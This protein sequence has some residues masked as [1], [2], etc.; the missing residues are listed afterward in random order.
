MNRWTLRLSWANSDAA[1]DPLLMSRALGLAFICG[2]S[3]ALAW[4]WFPHAHG[5]V[6]RPGILVT[7]LLGYVVAGILLSPLGARLPGWSFHAVV[8]SATVLITATVIMAGAGGLEL[9]LFYLWAMPPAFVFFPVRHAIAQ[10]LFVGAC[11]ALA[12]SS[13]PDTSTE[14]LIE[15]WIVLAGTVL[16]LGIVVRTLAQSIRHRDGELQRAFDSVSI[17][18]ALVS[19][20]GRWLEVNETLCSMLGRERRELVGAPLQA[21][22]HPDD[23][24]RLRERI[25]SRARMEGSSRPSEYTFVRA[26]GR[27]IPVE[28]RSATVTDDAGKPRYVF[29]QLRDITAERETRRLLRIS[30]QRRLSVLGEMMRAEEELRGRLATELHDDT[31]Q[32]MTSVLMTMDR[33]VRAAR[34][35]GADLTAAR[36]GEARAVLAEATERTRRLMFELRPQLLESGGLRPAVTALVE[37]A[38]R[39]AG[40]SADVAVDVGRYDDAAEQLVYRTLLELVTNVR[41]HARASRVTV[42]L[43][44]RDG[45]IRGVV[46]DDGAGFDMERRRRRPMLNIGLDTAEERVRLAGGEA[47][48]ESAPGKGTRVEFV[49]PVDVRPA[50]RAVPAEAVGD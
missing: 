24:S 43:R 44:E 14:V 6:N 25:S 30:E 22:V 27:H 16:M 23:Q 31:V 11:A 32:V 8:A 35:E 20:D 10:G 49:V 38:G 21:V 18:M 7:I 50:L 39:E 17:G 5:G 15:R 46:Q 19:L 48:V 9:T 26:D 45:L 29:C 1:A 34:Q 41:K 28:S 3:L 13:L 33:L 36:V 4:L 40:F 37:H 12:L 47:W 2:P 42:A